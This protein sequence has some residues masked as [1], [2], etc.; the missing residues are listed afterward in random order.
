MINYGLITL[1][2]ASMFMRLLTLSLMFVDIRLLFTLEFWSLG[3]SRVRFSFLLDFTSL[4]FSLTVSFIALRV[5]IFRNYYLYGLPSHNFFHLLLY[6]F[7]L[8]IILL[9]FRPNIF[10]LI[11]GWD[12]LGLS[13]YFLV[14][15]YKSSKAFNSGLITGIRNRVGDALILTTLAGVFCLP[16]VSIMPAHS[17]GITPSCIL[18]GVL[19]TAACTK[20]AQL[21]FRAW[22]PA[23]IAAPTPVSALVHSSTLVTAGV[24]LVIRIINWVTLESIYFL[25]ILGGLTIIIASFRAFLETDAKKII[26]L[27]T[28]SQ[29]GVMITSVAI[30]NH[31]CVFFHLLV[32]AFFKAL[33]FISTGVVIH[34]SGDYQDL[35]A[36]RGVSYRLPITSSVILFTK[37]SLIA[38]PFFSAFYSK[39]L[40]LESLSRHNLSPLCSYLIILIGVSLTVFYS[41]RFIYLVLSTMARNRAALFL[42]EVSG[43]LNTRVALLVLPSALSG[44]FLFFIL[45]DYLP[46]PLLRSTV[47]SLP[48]IVTWFTIILLAITALTL[49]LGGKKYWS[50]MWALPL[51]VGGVRIKN[52]SPGGLHL[53]CLLRFSSVDFWMMSWNS[54]NPLTHRYKYLRHAASLYSWTITLVLLITI[55]SV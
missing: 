34:N 18:V 13:S 36:V 12:G 49:L 21:P 40:V 30:S 14:I 35:R 42:G 48:L 45:C 5:F 39:E 10:S 17:C 28:L 38:L 33:L 41:A 16:S 25:S 52:F 20:S 53:S 23:A 4:I 55:L 47:K 19:V 44:K 54:L 46:V 6:T 3:K 24:Y 1:S 43:A 37:I 26:A 9:I 2:L 29:L 50:F 31:A 8:S 27:S 22:L 15:F 32:H 51:W 7:V 11:L